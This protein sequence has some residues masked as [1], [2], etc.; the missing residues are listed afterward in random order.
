M[1]HHKKVKK[2][3]KK[4]LR[5]LSKNRRGQKLGVVNG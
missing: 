2:T 3:S 5:V 1:D 4:K